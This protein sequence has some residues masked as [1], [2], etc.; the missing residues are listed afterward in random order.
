MQLV[1][2]IV[3]PSIALFLLVAICLVV[4]KLFVTNGMYLFEHDPKAMDFLAFYTGASLLF[5]NPTEMYS[6]LEQIKLQHQLLPITKSATVFLPFF[7]PPFVAL[8]LSPLALLPI[9]YAYTIWTSINILL[10]VLM[11]FLLYK[12]LPISKPYKIVAIFALLTFIP[13]LSSL[14]LG[15]L[16]FLTTFLMLLIWIALKTNKDMRAGLLFSFMLMKPHFFF[17][18]LL[19][20]IIQRRW[21]VIKGIALGTSIL[22]VISYLIVGIGG[23]HEYVNLLTNAA[24]WNTGYGIDIK[25]QHSLQ[26]LFLIIFQTNTLSEIRIPWIIAVSIIACGTLYSWRMRYSFDSSVF[27]LQFGLI[28]V[29]TLLISPHTHF[30]DFMLFIVIGIVLGY[31]YAKQKAKQLSYIPFFIVLGYVIC[32]TG[33]II[34]LYVINSSRMGWIIITVSYLLVLWS[35][36][37]YSLSKTK[38]K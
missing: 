32:L 12:H 26:T 17:L 33:Y 1:S 15:Q 21:H 38:T 20:F 2:K 7:N 9:L 36:L 4:L 27:A 35:F 13:V 24:T 14:L 31:A 25:A 29:A 16:T 18:P 19:G 34:E 5:Q 23:M 11:C 22:V 37:F 6:L 28:L 10:L 3:L 8:F 30:H